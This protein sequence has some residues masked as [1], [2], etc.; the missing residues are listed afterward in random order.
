M[1]GRGPHGIVEAAEYEPLRDELI[2]RFQALETA[3]PQGNRVRVFENVYK[4]EELYQ[5]RR[6]DN[7]N[8]PDLLLAPR[9][10]FAVVRKIRGKSPVRWCRLDRLEG[11]HREEGIFAAGGVNVRRGVR[12]DGNIVDIAPTM[13]AALGLKVPLDMEGRVLREVFVTE[14]KVE[15]EPPVESVFQEQPEIY[16]E[17]ERRVVAKRLS[18]LGYLE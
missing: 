8:L 6:E 7:P 16:S 1:R 3:D 15:R 13:L 11:T 10:G 12:V 4:T 5:C 17:Q 9:P 18:E 14:P 2:R